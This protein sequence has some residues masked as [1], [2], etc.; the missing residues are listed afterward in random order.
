MGSKKRG[1][2]RPITGRARPHRVMICLSPAAVPM[3]AQALVDAHA[4]PEQQQL[5]ERQ[6]VAVARLMGEAVERV[7]RA[8][9]EIVR[10]I[11]VTHAREELARIAARAEREAS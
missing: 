7:V 8:H 2:G 4:V 9:P 11:A 10:E 1:R 6:R 3:L 5:G